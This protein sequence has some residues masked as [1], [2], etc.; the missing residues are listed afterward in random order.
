MPQPDR[1]NAEAFYGALVAAGHNVLADPKSV[2]EQIEHTSDDVADESLCAKPNR[3][4]NDARA[5]DQWSDL[6]THF[7]QRHHHSHG[8]DQKDQDI[9]KDRKK[10]VQPCSPARLIGVRLTQISSLDQLTIN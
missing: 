10:G 2:I 7:R 1:T 3:H 6:H 4:A 9:A 5:C 8:D